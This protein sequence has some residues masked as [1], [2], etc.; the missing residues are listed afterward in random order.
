MRHP[1]DLNSTELEDLDLNFEEPLTDDEAQQVGGGWG[2]FWPIKPPICID[3][4]I[5]IEPPIKWPPD[6]EIEPLPPKYPGPIYTTLAL[7]EEGG[8]PILETEY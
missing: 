7:G 3:P 1:F 8:C 2:C 4:P 6:C 5:Y